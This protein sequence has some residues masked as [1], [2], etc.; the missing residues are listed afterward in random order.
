M[1]SDRLVAYL[2]PSRGG[3]LYE[4]D[5]RATKH[6]QLATLNRRPE[7]YHA[8]IRAFAEH[9]LGAD[10]KVA[11]I[12]SEVIFKQPGLEKKLIYDNWPRK[13]L[14]DHF[15]APGTP[16]SV[17]QRGDGDISDFVW[18]VYETVLKRPPQRAEVR[19]TRKGQVEGQNVV[20]TKTVAIGTDHPGNLEITYQL[21]QLSPGK[22]IH[23][24]VEFNFAGMA[25]G[26][27]DR[28]YYDFRGRQIGQLEAVHDLPPSGR[29]GLVDEWLG[30]DVSLEVTQPAGFWTFP[31]ETI[32]QSE[33][34][35][36]A[37]HQSSC[38]IPHWE[39]T[40]PE[41]GVW[42]VKIT[43]SID[44]SAAHARKLREAAT[45]G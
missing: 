12:Q 45:V 31:I 28:Y 19:M 26:A 14:V 9:R 8:R 11:S 39:I 13:S 22:K 36:E 3:H 29:I 23:F 7:S 2:A 38:V 16:L 10:D 24:G 25:A 42:S 5:I 40:A 33:G 41:D 43:L 32:S 4:L 21:E 20:V 18:G 35:Y 17:V 34:G 30:E 37:V 1:A 44:T 6:N 15:Y 27:A